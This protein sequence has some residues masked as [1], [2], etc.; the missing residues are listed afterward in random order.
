MDELRVTTRRLDPIVDIRYPA[1][2]RIA[3]TVPKPV[4]TLR[5]FSKA[6][7]A[8]LELEVDSPSDHYSGDEFVVHLR[9][10]ASPDRAIAEATSLIGSP[11][12]EA[13]GPWFEE[14]NPDRLWLWEEPVRRGKPDLIEVALG[15]TAAGYEV[16]IATGDG[17]RLVVRRRRRR[18]L[19]SARRGL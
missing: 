2:I 15:L 19:C 18:A 3:E 7:P 1:R 13:Y 16:Y 10:P 17:R 11:P 9:R 8:L 5:S 14:E 6:F 4:F 12:F